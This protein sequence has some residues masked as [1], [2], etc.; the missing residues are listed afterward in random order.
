[1]TKLQEGLKLIEEYYKERGIKPNTQI[2]IHGHRQGIDYNRAKHEL[3]TDAM[4][5][6]LKP[7]HYTY[8]SGGAW[9]VTDD[10][11][12]AIYYL[13]QDEPCEEE[14]IVCEL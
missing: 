1:M 9:E 14:D 7:F 5:L 11:G 4:E 3:V 6:N 12:R 10:E 13:Y 8:G 2:W